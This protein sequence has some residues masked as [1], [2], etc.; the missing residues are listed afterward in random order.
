MIHLSRTRLWVLALFFSLL[1]A[2]LSF[3]F[4]RS[5]STA[6]LLSTLPPA[7]RPT[8]YADL[9]LLRRAGIL[10]RIAG[11]AG[12]EE[13][14]YLKFV[15]A[16]SFDYRNDLDRLLLQFTPAQTNVIAAGR[17][18]VDRL[19]SYSLS[20]GGRC[21]SG[22][23]SLPGSVPE[24][25]IS[26]QPLA[27]NLIGLS[28]GPD[29]LAATAFSSHNSHPLFPVPAAALWLYLPAS[30]LHPREGLPPGASAFL[31]ALEGARYALLSVAAAP[32]GDGFSVQLEA[33]LADA[34]QASQVAAKLGDATQML[35]RLLNRE[36]RQP[37]PADLSGILAAGNFWADSA[38]VRGRWPIPPAFLDKLG[39]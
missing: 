23:C 8:L 14:D 4:L 27:R 30:E 12:A 39:R 18:H 1:L 28:S 13:P 16:T 24:R 20:S 19:R 6:Q 34:Q 5:P 38:T 29:P 17:F 35:K 3:Y 22:L 10:Q 31:S 26:W 25:Q 32:Q 33:P 7:D 2:G 11:Q 15:A 36:G 37:D 9:S 21:T